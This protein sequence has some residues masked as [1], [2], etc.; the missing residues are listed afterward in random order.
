MMRC[1]TEAVK[2][3]SRAFPAPCPSS[4]GLFP[5][6][7]LTPRLSHRTAKE[8]NFC[9]NEYNVT[10]LCSQQACPLANSR[11]ATVRSDPLTGRL[12]LYMKT[13][14][15]A[16]LP[17]R[18][19]ERVRLSANYA[20][21]LAQ[22]D[23][24]LQYWPAF[25]VHKCK[26]RLTRLTQV[27]IR[28]R[29]L[30]AEQ[31]R[32]GER[33]VA[34]HAPKVRARERTRER[35]AEAAAKVERVIERELLQRLREG[36]YGEQPLNVSEAIWHKV[37]DALEK[38]GEGVRDK[39][40]DKGIPLEGEEEEEE[41]LEEDEDEESESLLEAEDDLERQVEYVSDFEES[42]D[43]GDDVEDLSG[44]EDGDSDGEED[45]ED[46]QSDDVE[47]DK[48]K[49]KAGKRKRVKETAKKPKKRILGKR[50]IRQQ[51]FEMNTPA[52]IRL[53]EF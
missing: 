28:S 27:A 7:S 3:K 20:A 15:R 14:E 17:S 49:L 33:L 8:R 18:L 4:D 39:D 29:R 32:L 1:G 12:Y 50:L 48:D 43:E 52:K 5:P 44:G 37:L 13:V 11:Y 34:K 41:E 26:Q 45:S 2:P 9:R 53:T 47:T 21:A 31:D 51:V 35:K 25:L 10:G 16:H 36:A 30:A 23:A 46:E 22:L 19:W 42:D 24:R 38:E 6:T 40:R